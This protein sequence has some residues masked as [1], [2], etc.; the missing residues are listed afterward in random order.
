MPGL[1][2]ASVKRACDPS[3]M[4]DT[5]LAL[6][7]QVR[8]A[9]RIGQAARLAPLPRPPAQIIVAGM[10]G[11][12]IG[13]DL[14][15]AALGRRLSVPLI[16][17]RDSRMPAYVGPAS[18]VI[19]ASYSGETEET[20]A[21]AAEAKRSGATVL[22]ITSGQELADLAGAAV[23]VP[24]G[25]AP[26]AALGYL[27]MPA[28]AVL[29]RWRL[30]PPCGEEIEEAAGVL[31]EI[32]AECAASVPAAQNPAKRLAEALV[33]RIPAVYAAS[34]ELE[35]AARRWKCQFNENSKTFATWNMFSELTHNE[36]VGWAASPEVRGLVS[37]IV[38]FAG[39]EPERTL[40]R[41]RI[42]SELA[43]RCA[44]GVHD[45]RGRGAGRLARIL[46][47]VLLGDLVSIY[48]AYLRGVDPTPVEVIDAVKRRMGKG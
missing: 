45:A 42:T 34:P 26:R 24:G 48:L 2:D 46:S 37:P 14:L 29:E 25:L 12:A 4:L 11:S 5:A 33:G 32:A 20:L 6:P 3:G 30:V 9:W 19:A 47:L 16:V 44:A 38:L 35:A 27:M 31:D 43:F 8:D 15:A 28:L 17:S 7:G 36:T 10:G 21:A 40:R 39:D 18:V 22:A 13:G 23:R 1:D 41:I